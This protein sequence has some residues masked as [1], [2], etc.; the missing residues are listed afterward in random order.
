[1]AYSSRSVFFC[2]LP[3]RAD[4]QAFGE[5]DAVEVFFSVR[6]IV[7]IAIE[8]TEDLAPSNKRRFAASRGAGPSASPLESNALQNEM[9]DHAAKVVAMCVPPDVMALIGLLLQSKR[10]ARTSAVARGKAAPP[11]KSKTGR[12][13]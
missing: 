4:W 12:R 13:A 10:S 11:I 3:G 6:D 7:D 5:D 8:A 1:M 2:T 9:L